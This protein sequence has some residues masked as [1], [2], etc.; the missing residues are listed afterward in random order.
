MCAFIVVYG[1]PL[2]DQSNMCAACVS[3]CG[4]SYLT[5]SGNDSVHLLLHDG[6]NLLGH[7]FIY[8]AGNIRNC[9]VLFRGMLGLLYYVLSVFAFRLRIFL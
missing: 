4:V 6:G 5:L 7:S 1:C 3:V 8:R 9:V 2:G